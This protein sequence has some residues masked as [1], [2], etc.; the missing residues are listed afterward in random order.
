MDV[1]D[2]RQP[3]RAVRQGAESVL[4][5]V[6]GLRTPEERR[7]AVEKFHALA[8]YAHRPLRR[9]HV[10]VVVSGNPGALHPVS[11]GVTVDLDGQCVHAHAAG[12]STFECV[13]IV[14]QRLYAK[15]VRQRARRARERA[16]APHRR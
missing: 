5:E 14:R 2:G 15:L 11:L 6:I 7:Y 4:V 9:V 1:Y 10:T 16:T 3:S 13:D 8:D 12:E